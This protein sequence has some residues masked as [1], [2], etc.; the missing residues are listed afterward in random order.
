MKLFTIAEMVAAEKAA[1]AAGVS[2][3][4]MMEMAGRGVAEAIIER[5][6]VQNKT[7]L[8][9]VG[10]GNNGGD[11]LVAGRYL[12]E[13]G[14]AV[15]FYLMK[16]RDAAT[17]VNYAKIE[18]MNLPIIFAK[19]EPQ[20]SQLHIQLKKCDIL[21][22]ALLGTGVSRSI[23]G[24]LANLLQQIAITLQNQPQQSSLTVITPAPRPLR[25]PTPRDLWSPLPFIVG[26][27]SP[28]GMNCDTGTV[29]P[30]TISADLTVTFA[31]PKRGHFIF[32][33]AETCGELV[34]ADIGISTELPVVK[35]VAVSVATGEWV[36]KWLPKRAKDGH[37]GTFGKV[38]IAAGCTQYQGAPALAGR[39]AFRAGAGLV[40]LAV[41][42]G[43]RQTAVSLLPEATFPP[44]ADD[45]ILT[46]KSAQLLL[47]TIEQY[48]AVLLGPGMGRADSFVDELLSGLD[49][50]SIPP[51]VV[52]ADG[53]N[54]L[55][56]MEKWPQRLPPNT[57]LT[58]HLAEMGR[59]MGVPLSQIKPRD[60]VE[61]A[62]AQAQSWGHVVLLKGA[63]TVVASPDGKAT[64]LPFAN[65]VLAVGG[66]GDV[67][68]GVILALL[69][70]ELTPYGAAIVG[71]YLHG[72]AGELYA[73]DVGLLASEI[74]DLIPKV[75]ISN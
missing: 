71:G 63:Y 75:L 35:R 46:A 16:Q 39:G 10:P 69:G 58:P 7:V 43:V 57:I 68:S 12:A 72:S 65:P 56:R 38:L 9:L 21:I 36:R 42:K 37:K 19:D 70:Q 29:D 41:P 23:R 73:G 48:K 34:V 44:V 51:L 53:L 55:S 30:L 2:Y 54:I 74:A 24:N 49:I 8:I 33:G 3:A 6:S 26:V 59:L 18:Q 32:P 22:D 13:A 11:G 64:I 25:T 14:A 47:Q 31:G 1:D 66:S 15:T 17:D 61:M 67:L 50:V 28:S 40:G 62:M 5:V 45:D 27:D 52:D 60:R 20:L 4:A